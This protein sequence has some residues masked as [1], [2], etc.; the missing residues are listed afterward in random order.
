[1]GAS[2]GTSTV[3]PLSVRLF[4]LY[5]EIDVYTR[6]TSV[7]WAVSPIPPLAQFREDTIL[8]RTAG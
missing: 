1:M 2:G 5:F 8:A 4:T 6:H 7:L 3:L